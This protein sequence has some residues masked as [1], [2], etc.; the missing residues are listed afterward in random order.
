MKTVSL[1]YGN[2]WGINVSM[3]GKL[4]CQVKPGY[5]SRFETVNSNL[6]KMSGYN[7]GCNLKIL[8]C[9]AGDYQV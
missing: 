8:Q 6:T 3:P 7:S 5:L 1:K 2:D 4:D 9:S